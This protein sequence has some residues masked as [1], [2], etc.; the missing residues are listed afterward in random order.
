MAYDTI[1]L[2]AGLAGMLAALGRSERGERVLVLAKGHGATH[3]AAGCIDLFGAATNPL[4]AVRDLAATQPTHPY[5]LVGVTALEQG[6]ARLRAACEAV[7]YPLVGSAERSLLLPTAVGALRPTSLVPATMV[8]GESRQLGDGRPTL[9][10]G[11]RELRDFFPPLIAANLRAQGF[12][13]EGVYLDLP[14]STRHGAFSPMNF[15][16]LFEQPAFREQIGRQL[17]DLVRRG[18]Y[19]R[20]GLPGCLG[21]HQATTVVRDLQTQSGAL[22]FEI[23]TLPVSV[24][25]ARLFHALEQALVRAGGQMQIGAWVRRGEVQTE[26]L[27]AVYS[28]AAAREQRHTA[29]RWVLATGGI[30]GGGLR[31]EPT[32]EVRETALGLPVQV[33]AAQ[34]AWLAQR[35]LADAG[36]PIFRAGVATDRDLRPLDAAG[37][38]VYANVA[39]VGAAIAGF[40]PLREGCLEGVAVATGFAAGQH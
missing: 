39:V 37:R 7:G 11:L 32:G 22:I 23:P 40:D 24:P 6:L 26:Q 15:A 18:G 16:R 8:A 31:A 20:V 34:S 13:A 21:L 25:G 1:V 17:A 33:S 14:P 5:A 9:I 28:E 2:G 3:W 29:Q 12:T 27:V 4:A 10:A 30:A 36:H 35:F 19:A 38:V